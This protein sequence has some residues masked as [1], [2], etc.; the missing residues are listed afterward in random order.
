MFSENHYCFYETPPEKNKVLV[1]FYD[2]HRPFIPFGR[3]PWY[4]HLWI[5]PQ[6][7]AGVYQALE[8]VDGQVRNWLLAAELSL[9]HLTQNKEGHGV[10]YFRFLGGLDS[11][12]LVGG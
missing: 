11:W 4:Q 12:E 8:D 6:E 5:L 1:R 7:A 2:N 3:F 9:R 10:R